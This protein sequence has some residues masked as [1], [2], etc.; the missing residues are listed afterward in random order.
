MAQ[1]ISIKVGYCT[2]PGAPSKVENIEQ[3]C[4]DRLDGTVYVEKATDLI[5]ALAKAGMRMDH[6]KYAISEFIRAGKK[7]LIYVRG[8]AAPDEGPYNHFFVDDDW[9]VNNNPSTPVIQL[10]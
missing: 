8:F 7:T 4:A 5:N 10:Q 3:F 1:T 6:D 9:V 2:S